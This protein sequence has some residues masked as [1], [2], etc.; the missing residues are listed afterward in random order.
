MDIEIT[1][2]TTNP[3]HG[4]AL[5]SKIRQSIRPPPPS[6]SR[7][8]KNPF[9]KW[10]THELQEYLL[11][12][13][14]DKSAIVHMHMK[15]DLAIAA[16][17]MCQTQ[18]D[19]IVPAKPTSQ[20][21]IHHSYNDT[22][23]R[24]R[25]AETYHNARIAQHTRQQKLN[26]FQA[27]GYLQKH[28]MSRHVGHG[29]SSGRRLNPGRRPGPR[30]FVGNAPPPP[31][32][33]TSQYQHHSSPSREQQH[34]IF[35]ATG[36]KA[37]ERNA[38]ISDGGSR[39]VSSTSS[40]F[41]YTK[42]SKLEAMAFAVEHSPRDWMRF[43]KEND[44]ME[45][46]E[47][48][49]AVLHGTGGRPAPTGKKYKSLELKV[50]KMREKSEKKRYHG[51]QSMDPEDLIQLKKE[52]HEKRNGEF[53][54][55]YEIDV[56][57]CCA[58]PLG[59]HCPSCPCTCRPNQCVGKYGCHV[60]L[61]NFCC[62][63]CHEK[64]K[65]D[66]SHYGVGL[67]LYFKFLKWLG[68]TS[69]FMFLIVL[70]E[71]IVNT[72][73]VN[74]DAMMDGM[75][76]LSMGNLGELN[77]TIMVP[78]WG[79][80]VQQGVQQCPMKRSDI[81]WLYSILDC[82]AMALFFLSY[83]WLKKSE[84]AESAHFKNVGGISSVS[85]YTLLIDSFPPDLTIKGSDPA[86]IVQE[87][88]RAEAWLSQFFE[89]QVRAEC[90]KVHGKCDDETMKKNMLMDDKK[91]VIH[92]VIVA[93]D[94][95]NAI[96]FQKTMA[97]KR[98]QVDAIEWRIRELE[99]DRAMAI[100]ELDERDCVYI[101]KMIL[102][103]KK[104]KERIHLWMSK[105]QKD[106]RK[107]QIAYRKVPRMVAA[108]VTFSTD[109]GRRVVWSR[110]G[111]GSRCHFLC[112][113]K[114]A[115]RYHGTAKPDTDEYKMITRVSVCTAPEP[116]TMLWQNIGYSCCHK[117]CLRLL[118][119][120]ISLT[121][122]GLAAMIVYYAKTSDPST[123]GREC[124]NT[125]DSAPMD[126][127]TMFGR[128]MSCEGWISEVAQ[129]SEYGD[130]SV[131]CAPYT[132]SIT[133][134]NIHLTSSNSLARTCGC[135]SVA[136]DALRKQ[137][138]R[139]IDLCQRYIEFVGIQN[140]LQFAAVFSVIAVNVMYVVAAKKLGVCEHHSSLDGQESSVAFAVLL[141]SFLNTGLVMLLVNARVDDD[142]AISSISDSAAGGG[143]DV[144][145]FLQG[146][147]SDFTANWYADVGVAIT[148]TMMVCV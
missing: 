114:K 59:R 76:A 90:E 28:A 66:F 86:V 87:E 34:D 105:K 61:C 143:V 91:Q 128:E 30:P 20:T 102:K 136:F 113:Q 115:S 112:C 81:A 78:C 100:K 140:G 110:Y 39:K 107:K 31:P 88:R 5:A 109:L 73:G 8:I 135:R 85:D 42:P 144:T 17:Q 83:L 92:R 126:S 10:N 7:S 129:T 132:E 121:L 95:K 134:S 54:H 72:W 69:F 145:T 68:W 97:P 33:P 57:S 9:L 48:W 49:K 53:S 41:K 27:G 84:E 46:I 103:Q 21:D 123:L 22:K 55:A 63:P 101:D 117:T 2:H 47:K 111:G 1:E 82:A 75:H 70:P 148:I 138:D 94:Q 16:L 71:V 79:E 36:M 142:S 98:R 35:H 67:S 99:A 104:K 4:T 119:F 24:K 14:A 64:T 15:R 29:P 50:N 122:V 32:P 19:G 25:S 52:D 44:E 43:E 130:L 51:P 56:Y 74:N 26:R 12:N 58:T 106:Y 11:N 125:T 3:L 133:E 18:H 147:Y 60:D 93:S 89:D 38:P 118:T 131:A 124:L 116:S 62:D 108:L 127:I 23:Y 120:L 96:V 146:K 37:E 80:Y 40:S 141:G 6:S 65:S 45:Q 13:H 77:G 137:N 139:V